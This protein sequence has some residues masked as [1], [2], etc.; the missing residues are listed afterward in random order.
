[1]EVDVMIVVV[2]DLDARDELHDLVKVDVFGLLNNCDFQRGGEAVLG[3]LLGKTQSQAESR[4]R[5]F[6]K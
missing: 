3:R 1:M 6:E 5:R 2:G 4:E